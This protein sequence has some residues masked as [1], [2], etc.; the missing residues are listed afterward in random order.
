MT[1]QLTL[2]FGGALPSNAIH[3]WG[4]RAILQGTFID[5]LP[6]RQD[7]AGGRHEP[8]GE[9]LNTVGLPWL[10]A[11]VERDRPAQ[12]SRV[13]HVDGT[14]A[15]AARPA[16]GYLYI[17]A[18]EVAEGTVPPE[19]E[20]PTSPPRVP[21]VGEGPHPYRESPESW[22]GKRRPCVDCGGYKSDS[23][24]PRVRAGR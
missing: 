23:L 3:A 10:R 24:H 8:L 15:I 1:D 20:T 16:G 11:H 6:D 9:W 22:W 5:L 18:Y 19:V 7:I 13:A 14:Y 4:A 12:D 21:S 17:V 2:Q